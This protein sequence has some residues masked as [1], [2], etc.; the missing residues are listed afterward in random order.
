MILLVT[1][2]LIK[3]NNLPIDII[4]FLS[5]ENIYN[6]KSKIINFF[7]VFH[8]NINLKFAKIKFH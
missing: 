7:F 8:Y 1:L 5:L 4:V 2:K 6:E 3:N